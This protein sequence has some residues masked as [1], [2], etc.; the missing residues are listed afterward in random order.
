MTFSGR[1]VFVDHAA[2]LGG[3]ELSL[4]D[5]AEAHRDHAEVALFEDGP[6]RAALEQRGVTVTILGDGSALRSIKKGSVVPGARALL[7]VLSTAR[8]LRSLARGAAVLYT[9]SPKS[10]I[11]S[12]F[13]TVGA[14]TPVIWHLRDILGVEHFSRVNRS[15]AIMLAN[16]RVFRV[17]A[18]S[19]ATADAFVAAGG[20]ANRVRVVHNGIDAVPFDAL[21]PTARHDMR[22]SLGIPPDAFVA[23]S[24]SRLHPWKGQHV[25]LDALERLPGVQ[26]L[27]VGGALFS[28]DDA[29]EATLRKRAEGPALSGRVHLL[30]ARSDVPALMAACDVIV[31]ASVLPEPFGRVL[32]EA[33][34]ARRPVIA[35]DAGGVREVVRRDVTGML[36]PPGDSVALADAIA[37][38]RAEPALASSLVAAGASDARARFSRPAML[39]GV[40]AVLDELSGA[41]R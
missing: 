41:A 31:H 20:D 22:A 13:A 26:A 35:T 38:I 8:R 39:R 9:N 23:G 10:M 18:N 3:A 2:V 29:Y 15:I 4:L 17:I 25:L 28:G 37:R 1:I 5:I 36:V 40:A 14:A 30:G 19:Q 21:A 27:V 6:F 11:V 12:A 34:L 7:G 16:R 24:F 32:V 33:M